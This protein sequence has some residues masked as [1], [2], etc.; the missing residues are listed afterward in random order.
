MCD[1][2]NSTLCR[3]RHHTEFRQWYPPAR[4]FSQWIHHTRSVFGLILF[5]VKPSLAWTRAPTAIQLLTRWRLLG[6]R[7][8][9]FFSCHSQICDSLVWTTWIW[10]SKPLGSLWNFLLISN[11]NNSAFIN[12]QSKQKL[13]QTYVPPGF[14]QQLKPDALL[15]SATNDS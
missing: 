11:L 12:K 10:K 4:V 1:N 5:L 9:Y 14:M 7:W 3:H 6:S 15:G 2:G 13:T 8:W